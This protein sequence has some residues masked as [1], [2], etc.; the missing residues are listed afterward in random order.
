[1]RETIF[2]W[3]VLLVQAGATLALSGLIWFVQVVHYPLYTRVAAQGFA[4]YE[5][6]QRRR[7]G[8]VLW[9]LMVTETLAALLLLRWR[10]AGISLTPVI[11]GLFLVAIIWVATFFLQIPQHKALGK[12]FDWPVHRLLVRGSWIHTAAWTAR[13][14]ITLGM[15]ASAHH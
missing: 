8:W 3:V 2:A 15:L 9:P 13:A 5:E 11:A 12:G 10:P 6:E 4:S 1:M 7:T 14:G